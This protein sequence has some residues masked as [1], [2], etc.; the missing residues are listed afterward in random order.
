M[1]KR[2][3]K[4]KRIPGFHYE[5]DNSQKKEKSPAKSSLPVPQLIKPTIVSN[6]EAKKITSTIPTS[7]SLPQLLQTVPL[8]NLPPAPILKTSKVVPENTE[9]LDYFLDQIY[10]LKNSPTAYAAAVQ[11][12]IDKNYSLSIHKQRTK[13]F[14]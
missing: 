6:Q 7:Q 9:N 2:T 8:E 4:Q 10:K 11:K 5:M 1:S 12:Y 3:R 14:R 13:K